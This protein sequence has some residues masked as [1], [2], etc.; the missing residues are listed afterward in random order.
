MRIGTGTTQPQSADERVIECLP[1]N[2]DVEVICSSFDFGQLSTP[3]NSAFLAGAGI[4]IPDSILNDH[5]S[6]LLDQLNNQRIASC[7][8]ITSPEALF[9]E[10]PL[11][12]RVVNNVLSGR[13]AVANA[14][15]FSRRGLPDDKIVIFGGPCS[16]ES[17]DTALEFAYA[18]QPYIDATKE[19]ILF[20]MRVNYEKPRT[21][22][23]GPEHWQGIFP[24]PHLDGTMDYET[25]MRIVRKLLLDINNLGIPCAAEAL[26]QTGCQYFD[27]LL[28][29]VW[30]GAR[31]SSG[32]DLRNIFSGISAPVGLKH[33]LDGNYDTAAGNLA[34]ITSPQGFLGTSK[35]GE[36]MVFDSIGNTD[37]SIILRGTE[38]FGPNYDQDSIAQVSAALEKRGLPVRLMVDC[39]HNNSGS[40]KSKHWKN[41]LPAFDAISD[42][43]IDTWATRAIWAIM[44]ESHLQEGKQSFPNAEQ[45]K[46]IQNR[47]Q[48]VLEACQRGV[49]LTDGCI[50]AKDAGERM[51]ALSDRISKLK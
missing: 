7:H 29:F 17:P 51:V 33:G 35:L 12:E 31:N 26:S 37:A 9:C 42:S 45:I 8:K 6:R 18:M 28:S 2:A 46:Q 24:Q 14:M 25:G 13:R 1:A 50:S 38:E 27:D 32:H 3:G 10:F 43:V 22:V 23:T 41:Q 5:Y 20:V 48:T 4:E 15:N 11:T 34:T 16:I 39:S 47:G 36:S 21:M 19:N 49:S 30:L 40:K 44:V